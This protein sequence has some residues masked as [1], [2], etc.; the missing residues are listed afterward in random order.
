MGH[1]C[2]SLPSNSVHGS[3]LQNFDV[4]IQHVN[5]EKEPKTNHPNS[6][7]KKANQKPDNNKDL[8]RQT[9]G[10]SASNQIL[11]PRKDTERKA[12]SVSALS[13]V[14]LVS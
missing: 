2:S 9:N 1:A 3:Q 10:V 7:L 11:D 13:E 14:R 5:G 4:N 8:E 6:P 12:L